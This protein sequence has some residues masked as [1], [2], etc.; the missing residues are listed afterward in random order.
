[1]RILIFM[2][3]WLMCLSCGQSSSENP[4][5]FKKPAR[6]IITRKIAEKFREMN[7]RLDTMFTNMTTHLGFNGSVIVAK[8]GEIIYQK[9]FGFADKK[10][11]VPLTDSTMFQLASVSK[12]ITGTAVLML[13]EKG[14]IKLDDKFADYFPEFPYPDITIQHLLSHRSGLPNYMYFLNDVVSTK[15]TVM[16]NS[17]VLKL[18]VERKP[19]IYLKPNQ[20][21]N[22]CNT[23]YAL[24]ALLVEKISKKSFSNFLHE[25]IFRPLG[26][27]N[28]HTIL[29]MDLFEK[30]I[31][32]PYDNKWGL[33]E[34]EA[35]DYVLGDKSVYSTPYDLFLF[36]EALYQNKLLSAQTQQL[37]FTAYSREKKLT[38]YGLGWRMKDFTDTL[39]KE[40][41]H[42]GWWHGYR[43]S[44]HRRLSDKTT[45]IVLSNQL[46]R[47]AY[48][49][50]KIYR[51]LDSDTISHSTAL[52]EE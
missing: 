28:T 1:M 7:H 34:N 16:R 20:A 26:M 12:V 15:N 51:V 10:N 30:S 32:R 37:A 27:R 38:N 3:F 6:P 35:S 19:K 17:D 13:Y 9:C 48:Q 31:S 29:S 39:R 23:N 45:I 44:F 52:D 18:M 49:T 21:F 47:T 14:L 2:I 4:P 41:Y 50:Y 8:N 36:S 43:T 22:Y 46:N 24:L 42:N 40:V 11:N 33:I 5:R 25:E